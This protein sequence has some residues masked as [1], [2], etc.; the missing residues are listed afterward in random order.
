[1]FNG[2]EFTLKKFKAI[3]NSE[4]DLNR[5]KRI[6]KNERDNMLASSPVKDDSCGHHHSTAEKYGQYLPFTFETMMEAFGI[7]L[8]RKVAHDQAWKKFNSLEAKYK[9]RTIKNEEI[10]KVFHHVGE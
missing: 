6:V 2:N 7:N 5:F 1:M 9:A 8:Q 10:R 3:V 4:E